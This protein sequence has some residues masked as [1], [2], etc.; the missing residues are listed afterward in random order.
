[1]AAGP[2]QDYAIAAAQKYGVP[3]N[4]FLWQIGT[5]SS[6]NPNA[7]NPTPGSTATG[8]AQFIAPTAKAFGIDPLDPYASLDAAAKYDA[9]LYKQTGSWQEAMVKYGTLADASSD[10]IA[11]FKNALGYDADNGAPG[12]SESLQDFGLGPLSP[13]NW[14]KYFTSGALIVLGIVV[15]GVAILS[16]KT[17]QTIAVSAATKGKA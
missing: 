14:S 11:G 9:M 16:N 17:V 10:K 4:M 13:N 6:W 7:R 15:I 1:M 12:A 3:Q 5:E 2:Y 8:I